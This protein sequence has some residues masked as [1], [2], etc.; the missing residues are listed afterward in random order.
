MGTKVQSKPLKKAPVSAARVEAARA[1]D[2]GPL[3]PENTNPTELDVEHVFARHAAMQA[4]LVG[5]A[6]TGVAITGV[7]AAAEAGAVN[8]VTGLPFA[9]IQYTKW[10]S[11][12]PLFD[13]AWAE[14][15]EAAYDRMEAEAVQRGNEGSV[16]EA[17]Y[18]KDGELISTKKRRSD[19]LL[20]FM[21]NGRR[22]GVF[23]TR[24]EITGANGGPLQMELA[25]SDA[26][27]RL[28]AKIQAKIASAVASAPGDSDASS[29]EA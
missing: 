6:K 24:T 10:R 16:E 13:A 22:S 28:A 7:D 14:A 25:A 9:R 8:P 17:F 11:E 20:M 21:L 18:G 2:L 27:A 26:R 3:R 23:R 15:A 19:T 4:F 29:T 1:L 5:V 12:Y